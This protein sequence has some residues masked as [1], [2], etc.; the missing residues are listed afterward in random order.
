MRADTRKS[1]VAKMMGRGDKRRGEEKREER[2]EACRRHRHINNTCRLPLFLFSPFVVF[3][4]LRTYNLI[5]GSD[6]SNLS[7]PTIHSLCLS[8]SSLPLSFLLLSASVLIGLSWSSLS[9]NI[10][11]RVLQNETD[12][13]ETRI[14]IFIGLLIVRVKTNA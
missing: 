4:D 6:A 9:T 12:F 1:E 14:V 10:I 2:A 5:T 3:H 11:M 7:S 13:I 8:I